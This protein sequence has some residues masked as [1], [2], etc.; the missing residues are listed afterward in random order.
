MT[1]PFRSPASTD[2]WPFD[3]LSLYTRMARDFGACAQALSQCTDA[4]EAMQAEAV[5]G[6]RLAEDLARAYADLALLPWTVMAS[7]FDGRQGA[8]VRRLPGN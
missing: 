2:Y 3:G 4:M 1:A 5:L 6:M 7:A 8:D